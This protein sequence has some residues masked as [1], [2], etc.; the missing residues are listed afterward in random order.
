ML[1]SKMS[2][3]GHS[4][5]SSMQACVFYRTWESKYFPSPPLLHA[6]PAPPRADSGLV[7]WSSMD[8]VSAHVSR[9]AL[10]GMQALWRQHA[11]GMDAQGKA[12]AQRVYAMHSEA[13][14]VGGTKSWR[15]REIGR[16][17]CLYGHLRYEAIPLHP[18][19]PALP[20]VPAAPPVRML[21]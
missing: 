1:S 7:D 2:T 15:G 4:H 14:K 9:A 10:A 6:C 8:Q 3:S 21:P 16:G 19:L 5:A 11:G 18:E 20:P 12:F 17:R 13:I